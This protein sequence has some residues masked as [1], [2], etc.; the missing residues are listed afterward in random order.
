MRV[1][2]SLL[3][4]AV[5]ALCLGCQTRIPSPHVDYRGFA[6]LTHELHDLRE[7]RRVSESQFIDMANMSDTVILDS[8]SA[9]KFAQM[10]IAG[11]VNVPFSEITDATLQ[12]AI[13]SRSTRVLIYCNN[14]FDNAPGPFPMK[15]AVAALNVPTFITLH[16]YGYENVYELGPML[17]P[18]TSR[19]RFS[20]SSSD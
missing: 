1:L 2:Y 3:P 7:S 15:K 10:H 4:L 12:A 19:L 5:V 17:D 20:S 14:N 6:T 11:A 9:T 13:P 8:R 16:A 18:A